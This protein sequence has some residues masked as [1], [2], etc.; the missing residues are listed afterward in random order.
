[1]MN[2][3]RGEVFYI[4][5]Y[6]NDTVGTEQDSG[7]PFLVVSPDNRTASSGGALCV[8]LTTQPKRPLPQH[9]EVICKYQTSTVL[10]EQLRYID[11]SRFGDY[12]CTLTDAEMARVEGC[13]L[14]AVGISA[15]VLT[16]SGDA[17]ELAEARAR[18]RELERQL[19][20][21]GRGPSPQDAEKDAEIAALKKEVEKLRIREEAYLS[22]IKT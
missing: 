19:L 21:R 6:E 3:R 14:E 18:I 9:C 1:M 13:L 15:R 2:A 22:I 8:P 10:C 7:R 20:T 16:Q 12:C 11:E 4:K 17:V 5:R